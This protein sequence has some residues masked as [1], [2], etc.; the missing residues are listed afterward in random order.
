LRNDEQNYRAT[1][2][3]VLELFG[4]MSSALAAL[5][6]GRAADDKVE[7]KCRILFFAKSSGLAQIAGVGE[8][9]P[10]N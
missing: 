6:Y 9:G 5:S 2:R 10:Q 4:A 1:R 3:R 7:R 8:A